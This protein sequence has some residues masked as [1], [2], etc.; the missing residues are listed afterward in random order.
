[1]NIIGINQT[2]Y[3]SSAA[4][5]KDGKLIAAV[6]EE[7]FTRKKLTRMFPHNAFAFCLKKACISI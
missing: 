2:G 3:I 4:V 7:R 5:L 1:M 6:A